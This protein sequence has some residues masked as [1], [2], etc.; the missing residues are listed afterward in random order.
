MIDFAKSGKITIRVLF[1]GL[2]SFF[3]GGTGGLTYF[4]VCAQV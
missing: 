2:T 4:M 1:K 3:G